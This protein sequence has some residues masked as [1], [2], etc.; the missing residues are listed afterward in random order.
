M[1]YVYVYSKCSRDYH[2]F[3]DPPSKVFEKLGDAKKLSVPE[4]AAK[5]WQNTALDT[6]TLYEGDQWDEEIGLIKRVKVTER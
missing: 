3:I 2:F 6:W 5:D 4:R 1:S